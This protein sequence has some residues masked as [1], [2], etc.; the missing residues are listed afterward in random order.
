MTL[1]SMFHPTSSRAGQARVRGTGRW[2]D[3]IGDVEVRKKKW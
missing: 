1:Y 2:D 3:M